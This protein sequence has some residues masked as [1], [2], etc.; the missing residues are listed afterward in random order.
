MDETE[1]SADFQGLAYTPKGYAG[2]MGVGPGWQV[3]DVMETPRGLEWNDM[4]TFD[5]VHPFI[6]KAYRP[7]TID[8]VLD[9]WNFCFPLDHWRSIIPDSGRFK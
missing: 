8:G 1:N 4:A 5:F 6:K 2:W 9:E 3:C 7:V